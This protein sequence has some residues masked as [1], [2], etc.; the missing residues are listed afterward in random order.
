MRDT[1]QNDAQQNATQKNDARH[2]ELN[3][4][5]V[6]KVILTEQ[7][8]GLGQIKETIK[9]PLKQVYIISLGSEQ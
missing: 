1:Q 5:T 2:N 3:R 9:M 4:M 7:Y 8:N 6:I